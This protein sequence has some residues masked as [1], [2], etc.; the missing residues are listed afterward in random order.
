VFSRT[1]TKAV[2]PLLNQV[3]LYPLSQFDGKM[4]TTDWSKMPS[5]PVPAGAVGETKWVVPEKYYDQLPGVMKL[6]P[7]LPG[8]EALKRYVLALQCPRRLRR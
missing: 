6:V 3:M 5:F 8:E 7:P 1:D 2:Q 4:K